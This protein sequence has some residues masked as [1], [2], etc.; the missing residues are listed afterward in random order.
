MYTQNKFWASKWT[1][2]ML[3]GCSF[4]LIWEIYVRFGK[5]DGW[6]FATQSFTSSNLG[7]HEKNK[8]HK[9]PIC[10]AAFMQ[11]SHMQTH[12]DSVHFGKKD[13]SKKVNCDVCDST[14]C[15][16][17]SLKKHIQIVHERKKPFECT[18]CEKKFSVRSGLNGH[19]KAMHDESKVGLHL[20]TVFGFT[21]VPRI[22]SAD[23]ILF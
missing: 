19:L 22:V 4:R 12:V 23:T 8:P 14:F 6:L 16:K 3:K 17:K 7:V 13:E 10:P 2:H 9:C 21:V 20:F 18:F 1:R 5:K 11:K 15:D